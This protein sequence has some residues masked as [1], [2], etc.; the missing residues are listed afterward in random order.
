[1]SR[2]G[3]SFRLVIQRIGA[4]RGPRFRVIAYGDDSMRAWADFTTLTELLDALGSATPNII[5]DL[6]AD[7]SIIFAGEIALD[8]SQLRALGLA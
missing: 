1:M 5:L 2:P 3:R 8:D 7:H 4:P 6:R